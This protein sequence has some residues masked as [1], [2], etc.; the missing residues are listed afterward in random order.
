MGIKV[1][2]IEVETCPL[3]SRGHISK[4]YGQKFSGWL[5]SQGHVNDENLQGPSPWS[6]SPIRGGKLI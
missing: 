5:R 3:D 6:I 4:S 1:K 2:N